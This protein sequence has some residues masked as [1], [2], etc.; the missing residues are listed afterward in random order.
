MAVIGLLILLK[1]PIDPTMFET[2]AIIAS[3]SVIV[4]IAGILAIKVI[5]VVAAII[6][7]AVV[8]VILL[9]TVIKSPG[10][11]CSSSN[12][13]NSHKVSIQE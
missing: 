9:I 4:V 2:F 8:A 3:L 1:D 6:V 10:N 13:R 7:I 12:S 11:V 5:V